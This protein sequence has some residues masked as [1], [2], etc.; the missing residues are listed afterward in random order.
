MAQK[1]VAFVARSF[2]PA[3]EAK[4]FPITKFL[5]SF[6]AVGFF[7]Q[8][9]ER[10]E[11][12][13]VSEKVRSLIDKSDV[14][15]GIFTKRHPVYHL[16]ARLRTALSLFRARLNPGFWTAPPWVL[17][18]SGYALKARKPLILFRETDVE[19]PGLQ[20][21]LEYIPFD[22]RDPTKALQRASEMI[23]SLIA[24]TSGINID[25]VVQ[26]DSPESK[27]VEVV[28]PASP[29]DSTKPDDGVKRDGFG[30]RFVEL[31]S[32]AS[33][34]DWEKTE[35]VFEDSLRWVKEHD[36]EAELL[37]K[38]LYAR[39]LFSRG[40]TD[41]LD[42]LRELST[43]HP[44]EYLPLSFLASCLLDLHE[45][46]EAARLYLQAASVV[47]PD[48]RA[49]LEI[50][51]A[52][53]LKK[54]KKTREARELL[55]KVR[56]SNYAQDS[57]TQFNILSNLYTLS[58]EAEDRFPSLAIAELALHQNP[59][60]SSFRFSLAYDYEA[61]EHAQLAAYHYKIICEHDD[62]NAAALNNLGIALAN[63]ELPVLAV[64]RYK[65]SYE[66]GETLA[67]SNLGRRY[68]EAGLTDEAI[69]LLNVAQSKE[70]C[71]QEVAHTVA[72]VYERID[73]NNREQ[74]KMLAGAG[75]FRD[76]I[77]SF[78][79]GLLSQTLA[80]LEGRWKFPTVRIDL[81]C[82]DSEL[83]GV[84]EKSSQIDA[85]MTLSALLG[86]GERKYVKRIE[87]F[88]FTGSMSGRT[89]KFKLARSRR[90][91]PGYLTFADSS[92]DSTIEGYILFAQ[93]G[94]SG[95]VAQL[96]NGEPEKYYNISKVPTTT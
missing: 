68:L 51:A 30:K 10:S 41:A 37:W 77:L 1:I 72:K 83:K 57:K 76:F 2:D 14:F 38:C 17:Q 31:L 71:V 67:A 23:N 61:T 86:S 58:K 70:N 40:R 27:S 95:R 26:S 21:D 81:K 56:A 18:E 62:K 91:E 69:S 25:T 66:L 52:G 9:A 75:E 33:S 84:R 22:P 73:E 90:D 44:G 19:I 7:P 3:D 54:A 89:C 13:S 20:G 24:K 93:D 42:K 88:E 11:V 74:E 59:A 28:P 8:S 92:S 60:E 39:A 34:R 78:G 65:Q 94:Q 82:A 49:S 45:N 43:E 79:E 46:D 80:N 87:T 55:L 64:Q 36:P 85:S 4:I 63:C 48:Q 6:N 53:A 15:V 16:D 35:Q 32:V 12:E 5:A 47:E 96:K 29:H 50:N